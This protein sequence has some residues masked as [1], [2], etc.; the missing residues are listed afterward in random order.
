MVDY[1]GCMANDSDSMSNKN[2]ADTTSDVGVQ[3]DESEYLFREGH[4]SQ[5]PFTEE[6]FVYDDERVRFY[7]GLTSFDVL[8]VTFD[9]I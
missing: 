6:Y 2:H 9:F 3:T 8:K 4:P 1:A 5:K 7:T